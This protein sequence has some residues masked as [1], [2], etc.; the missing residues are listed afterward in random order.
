MIFSIITTDL[1]RENKLP[2]RAVR[3]EKLFF[4]VEG[5]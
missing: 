2:G 5:G 1:E 4:D 3:A